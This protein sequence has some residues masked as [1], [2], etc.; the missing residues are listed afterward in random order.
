MEAQGGAAPAEGA[1]A[2]GATTATAEAAPAGSGLP[3]FGHVEF[4]GTYEGKLEPSGRLIIP[5]AFRY[6]FTEGTAQLWAQPDEHIA[7]FTRQGF[8]AW[9]DDLLASQPAELFDPS[10]RTDVYAAAP[11]VPIDRQFRLVVPPSLR[12]LVP[13]GE[14]I[15]FAGTLE[16]IR[17]RTR[18]G[19]EQSAD[20]ARTLGLMARSHPGLSTKPV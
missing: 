11:K 10:L 1:P 15:V 5:A 18:Q 9:V 14:D 12:D 4:S 16:Q 7:I 8:N 20:R 17:V 6:A 3:V 2:A 13:L 19:G